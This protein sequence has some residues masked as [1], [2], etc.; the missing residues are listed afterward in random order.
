MNVFPPDTVSNEIMNLFPPDTVSN[1]I[2]NVFPPDTVSNEWNTL[3]ADGYSTILSDINEKGVISATVVIDNTK[4]SDITGKPN[5]F[6]K[7]EYIYRC[8]L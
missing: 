7:Y 5:F 4:L 8:L 2:M 1:E 3:P 6:S